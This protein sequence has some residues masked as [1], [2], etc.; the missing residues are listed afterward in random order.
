MKVRVGGDKWCEVVSMRLAGKCTPFY[1][2]QQ[3]IHSVR[4]Q[5]N[6]ILLI[7]QVILSNT[8]LEDRNICFDIALL[9]EDQLWVFSLEDQISVFKLMLVQNTSEHQQQ[10]RHLPLVDWKPIL[11]LKLRRKLLLFSHIPTLML[12]S[13]KRS[14]HIY[15]SVAI[16]F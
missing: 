7:K 2:Y 12:L 4:W 14:H 13:W 1:I 16:F 8:F 11:A 5:T 3:Y 6:N 10:W 9:G 15:P